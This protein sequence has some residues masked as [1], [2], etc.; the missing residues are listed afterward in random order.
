MFKPA[1]MTN[2][3]CI[4]ENS[5]K[6]SIVRALHISGETQLE[7][8]MEEE[9]K[10]KGLMKAVS[11][12]K[13]PEITNHLSRAKNL[14]D[15]LKPYVK[16]KSSF[17]DEMLGVEETQQKP[18]CYMECE[19]LLSDA[20][21][22]LSKLGAQIYPAVEGLEKQKAELETTSSEKD[23]ILLLKDL[24]IY[25]RHFKETDYLYS[26]IGVI[27]TDNI[28]EARKRLDEKLE[29]IYLL[30]IESSG[31]DKSVVSFH[32][33]KEKRLDLNH[34]LA[35][36][37]YDPVKVQ[38]EKTY[39]Q[40]YADYTSKADELGKTVGEAISNL[41]A[42][43]CERMRALL[44]FEELL[45][46]ELARAKAY[47]HLA[48][49]KN[50]TYL[51]IWVPQKRKQ[52]IL[53]ILESASNGLM[54][55]SVSDDSEDAPTLLDNPAPL[56]PFE[57]FTRLF[58][59]PKYNQLDPTAMTAPSFVIFFGFM[60]GDAVYGMMILFAS[61]WLQQKYLKHMKVVNFA[62]ILF[63]CG[64]STIVFGIATGG[65]LG[66]ALTKYVLGRDS[67]EGLWFVLI[68]PLYKTNAITLLAV[69]VGIGMIHTIFGNVLGIFDKLSAGEKKK[70]L[71]EN[72]SW[73]IMG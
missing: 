25:A 41:E 60:L 57:M 6:D 61:I 51:R 47:T 40:L 18:Y 63:W 49:T 48:S 72:G 31:K 35:G 15:V 68:D 71:Q 16:T 70:A 62:K 24:N 43:A 58:S 20:D 53:S 21:D 13:T 3:E 36:A 67:S 39:R 5:C 34:V 26:T 69:A 56:K 19:K 45:S 42:I 50:T 10:E 11:S 30:T 2:I 66:D 32:C 59:Q 28:L 7:S 14:I 64:L 23:S 17:L 1:Q 29:K 52:K 65:F 73:L 9:M 44:E 4:V 37:S 38:G 33:I 27:P 22:I 46:N 54:V 55:L 12:D 8:I